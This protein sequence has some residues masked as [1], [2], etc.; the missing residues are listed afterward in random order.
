[1]LAVI[2]LMLI[3]GVLIWRQTVLQRDAFERSLLQ[4]A[5]ALSLAVDRQLFADRVMLETLAQSPF[6]E[7]RDYKAFYALCARVVG[8]QGALFIS[9]FDARGKQIF[10][11]LRAP[12]EALPTPFEYPPP[13]DPERPPIG[14]PTALQ[15]VLRTGKPVNSDLVYGLV[16]GR[17]IFLVNIPVIRDGRIRYVLNAGFEPAV[18]TRLLQ[19]SQQFAGVPAWIWDRRGF[20][21][22]RWQNA[23]DYVGRRVP[24]RQLEQIKARNAGVAKGESAE[25]IALYYSYARSPVS[26]WTASVGAERGELDHAVRAGWIIGGALMVGGVLLGLLLALSIAARLRRAIVSLAAAASRNEPPQ[27]VGLRTREIELLEHAVLEAAQAS[28]ARLRREQAEAESE[29]KDRYIATLSH[30]LRNPLAA[31]N[32]AVYLLGMEGGK[33]IAPTLGMMQRQIA[34]LTRMV[35]DLLDVSRVTHGKIT[36]R[37]APT[38][39]A[40]V[41]AQAIETAV[42]A[43]QAKRLRFTHELA[44]GTVMVRGDAARL[45]QVFSNLFDNAAKFTPPGGEVGVSLAREDAEARVTVSDNGAGIDPAFLPK[46]F[47]PFTQADTSLERATSG[48]GLGLALARQIVEAHGGTISATSAGRGQGSRFTVRLP[49]V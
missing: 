4:T 37:P 38:D 36:L 17:L 19:E 31:L 11:T 23:D 9:L 46:M 14:D 43:L 6:L 7:R 47:E 25:G 33:E 35:N 42:P 21:V 10:N 30:E 3:A 24:P 16:A 45:L 2:P 28:E 44:P 49:L 5:Q 8:E 27:A 39:L 18:M 41:L 15:E 20:I 48:L 22:G 26:G 12:G 34:Q 1:M 13:P 29:T 32:N 40:A